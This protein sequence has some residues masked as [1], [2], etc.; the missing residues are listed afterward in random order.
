MKMNQNQM[1]FLLACV[2][3][4]VLF[5][6]QTEIKPAVRSPEK[7]KELY[8]YEIYDWINSLYWGET[9]GIQ[10]AL[11]MCSIGNEAE[12]TDLL[13]DKMD[14]QKRIAEWLLENGFC[15]SEPNLMIKKG[16]KLARKIDT[17]TSESEMQEAIRWGQLFLE[18]LGTIIGKWRLNSIHNRPLRSIIYK[19]F[20]DERK[21]I[22]TG[23]R[24]LAELNSVSRSRF[25]VVQRE[26]RSIFPI[27]IAH[28][29][30]TKDETRSIKIL[31][32][33]VTR[34]VLDHVK[35][36]QSVYKPLAIIQKWEKSKNYY[37]FVCHPARSESLLLEPKISEDQKYTYDTITFSRRHE[38][39]NGVIH[40]GFVSMLLDE[41]LCYAVTLT[42][43]KLVVT[44]KL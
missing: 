33:T 42:E 34:R 26:E 41:M 9:L 13:K 6:G 16:V 17:A 23:K 22:A 30:L 44:T 31:A 12:W 43:N 37:C 25:D 5:Y 2:D 7:L 15:I 18:E 1:N 11:K 21:H 24:I 4:E 38:G 27:H 32:R 35:T 10:F 29:L 8:A 19:I 20:R 28:K 3:E 14:H 39:L 36:K 40:G